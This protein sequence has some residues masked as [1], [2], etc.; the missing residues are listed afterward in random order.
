M[1][2]SI[3]LQLK[4]AQLAGFDRGCGTTTTPPKPDWLQLGF[5]LGKSPSISNTYA[6]SLEWSNY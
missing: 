1:V 2:R 5:F 6:I 3:H 4:Q